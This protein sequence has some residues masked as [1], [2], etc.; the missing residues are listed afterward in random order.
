MS[1]RS[2]GDSTGKN[3]LTQVKRV[4]SYALA[5]TLV[6]GNGWSL[7]G[8]KCIITPVLSQGES[9]TGAYRRNGA[10]AAGQIVLGRF[11]NQVSGRGK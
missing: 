8:A 5:G 7:R 4:G 2:G 3:H 9:A 11:A 1:R 10:K 6:F